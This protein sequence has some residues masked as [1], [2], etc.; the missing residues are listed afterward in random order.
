MDTSIP[1]KLKRQISSYIK[2]ART[3][4]E[5][6][7]H[8][9]PMAFIGVDEGE[10]LAVFPWGNTPNAEIA[11]QAIRMVC[12]EG[13][14]AW[15]I[16]IMEAWIVTGPVGDEI[17]LRRDLKKYGSVIN[18]PGRRGAVTFLVETHER[19]WNGTAFVKKLEGGKSTFGTM[20][21]ED[22]NRSEGRFIGMLPNRGSEH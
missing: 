3:I 5:A 18:T 1:D 2:T 15:V 20:E 21:F 19:Q 4:Y 6:Q 16:I 12:K 7:G 9:A 17:S 14:A 13:N 11:S 22:M 8:L 10:G